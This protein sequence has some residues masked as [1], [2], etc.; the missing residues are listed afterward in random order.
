MSGIDNEGGTGGRS[1][2]AQ[3]TSMK[4]EIDAPG[5][6]EI[7]GTFDG[8]IKADAVVVEGSGA[9]TGIIAAG[10]VT[11]RGNFNGEIGTDE[12]RV[13]SGATIAGTVVTKRLLV[14]AGANVDFA[15]RMAPDAKP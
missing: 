11:V 9:M 13:L 14:E 12:L 3:R 5:S 7:S 15:C 6:V 1:V 8:R 4:G 2:L 10:R